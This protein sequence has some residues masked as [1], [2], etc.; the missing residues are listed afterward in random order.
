MATTK[1]QY[2]PRAWAEEKFHRSMKRFLVMILHRRAGKTTG[3]VNHHQRA[4]MSDAWEGKRLKA[5]ITKASKMKMTT[6][7]I[8]KTKQSKVP[9]WAMSAI[10]VAMNR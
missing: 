7:T 10:A 8:W 9:I 1:I 3:I 5:T 6:P 2:R 4:A